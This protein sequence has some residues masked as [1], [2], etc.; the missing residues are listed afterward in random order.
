VL[1]EAADLE[2][3]L[4]V[5]SV[6]PRRRLPFRR[7]AAISDLDDGWRRLLTRG[8]R[9]D[10]FD[11][12]RRARL[13]PELAVALRRL[14]P[15]V[16]SLAAPASPVPVSPLR[17]REQR[18]LA[19]ATLL[20]LSRDSVRWFTF[21]DTPASWWIDRAAEDT[22]LIRPA[23]AMVLGRPPADQ[24]EI[25]DVLLN[26]SDEMQTA[27]NT[28]DGDDGDEDGEPADEPA[29]EP[30]EEGQ[31]REVPPVVAGIVEDALFARGWRLEHPAVRGVLLGPRGDRVDALALVAYGEDGKV[32]LTALRD[33][34]HP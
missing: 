27:M 28:I 30:A 13:H 15:T 4:Y 21:A 31:P 16:S 19:R 17:R 7:I 34:L 9:L 22:A 10:W 1:G 20:V 32:D 24:L 33:L 18:R 3:S 14:G 6:S 25:I 26:R 8:I 12:E 23:A 29:D 2:H 5:Y 11:D